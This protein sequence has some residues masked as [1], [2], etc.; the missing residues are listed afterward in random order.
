MKDNLKI[1]KNNEYY[2]PH[3]L[4]IIL[5]ISL[6][7]FS[8]ECELLEIVDINSY[9]YKI[10]VRINNFT[11]YIKYSK[12]EIFIEKDYSVNWILQDLDLALKP[13][14]CGYLKSRKIFYTLLKCES[15]LSLKDNFK[16][17]NEAIELTKNI[18]TKFQ[19]TEIQH[20]E[21]VPSFKSFLNLK[22]NF[23]TVF[24]LIK[25]NNIEDFNE[26][27]AWYT[28]I[29]E[30]MNYDF[31][32]KTIEEIKVKL[33]HGNLNEFNILLNSDSFVLE[34]FEHCLWG[35]PIIDLCIFCINLNINKKTFLEVAGCNEM[36]I[37][38]YLFYYD[39]CLM[40][41]SLDLIVNIIYC[42]IF[43]QNKHKSIHTANTLKL[44]FFS[45]IEEIK[46]IHPSLMRMINHSN[47]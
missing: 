35:D 46:I 28:T 23:M 3:V 8:C 10:L 36:T 12:S 20:N 2:N 41:K 38:K 39:I 7:H 1:F 43:P 44:N 17:A 29:H 13:I 47:V 26:I 15:L 40:K 16:T 24:P 45:K 18:L 31:N 37:N 34:D 6:K 42:Y 14:D 9:F 21:K 22:F 25:E 4:D 27:A 19:S 11:L 32:N 5:E 30:K 33:I